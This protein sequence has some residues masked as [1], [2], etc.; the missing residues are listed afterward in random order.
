MLV[1]AGG[2][3][4]RVSRLGESVHTYMHIYIYICV[5]VHAS[6]ERNINTCTVADLQLFGRRLLVLLRALLL[7][8]LV[9]LALL[10]ATVGDAPAPL[11]TA[12]RRNDA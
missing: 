12:E 4:F 9:L 1:T 2:E 6:L 10:V 3:R 8:L 7:V 5:C 11:L